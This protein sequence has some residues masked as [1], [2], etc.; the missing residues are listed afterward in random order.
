MRYMN[1]YG[2][3]L[4]VTKSLR[5]GANNFVIHFGEREEEE[6]F[7]DHRDEIISVIEER[8]LE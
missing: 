3:L 7:S 1:K 4:G 5:I 2:D 6:W 8:Y